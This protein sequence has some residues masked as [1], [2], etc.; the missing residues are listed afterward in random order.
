MYV[1]VFAPLS[2]L[3]R[4]MRM[5]L[6]EEILHI[7]EIEDRYIRNDRW[8]I[9]IYTV[10]VNKKLTFRCRRNDRATMRIVLKKRL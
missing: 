10:A 1:E 2:R 7:V 9:Y 8:Q 6:T 4:C 3:A 5:R